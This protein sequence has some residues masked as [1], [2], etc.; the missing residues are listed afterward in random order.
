MSYG[1]LFQVDRNFKGDVVLGRRSY[2][3]VGTGSEVSMDHVQG[4][5]AACPYPR[6]RGLQRHCLLKLGLIIIVIM[7]LT[8]CLF[9]SV[10]WMQL[11]TSVLALKEHNHSLTPFATLD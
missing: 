5:E 1:C 7:L 10:K 8:L 2:Q 9:T 3:G 4:K 6:E 11:Q